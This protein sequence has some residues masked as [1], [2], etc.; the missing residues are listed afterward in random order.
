MDIRRFLQQYLGQRNLS[1]NRFETD[2][3]QVTLPGI[4]NT[5]TMKSAHSEEVKQYENLVSPWSEL[6]TDDLIRTSSNTLS[7]GLGM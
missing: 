4:E 3:E 7:I 1:Q 6:N 5:Y 2:S